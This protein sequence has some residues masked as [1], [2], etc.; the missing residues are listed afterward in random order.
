MTPVSRLVL[1]SIVGR[2]L[3]AVREFQL[4]AEHALISPDGIERLVVVANET[5]PGPTIRVKKGDTVR[6]TV[7]NNLDNEGL[8]IHWH[9]LWMQNTPWADGAAYTTQCPML[10][11]QTLLYEFT[12]YQVR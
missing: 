6:V 10:D 2:A 4:T 9:G 8:S 11:K 7:T 12:A 3:A 1:L 5:F